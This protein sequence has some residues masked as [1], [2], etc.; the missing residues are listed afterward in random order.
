M[1]I[2]LHIV[3]V[4]VV[5]VHKVVVVAEDKI[6]ENFVG[7]NVVVEEGTLVVVHKIVVVV[8]R[9]EG[10]V[11]E[12]YSKQGIVV[13]SSVGSFVEVDSFVHNF[14]VD[15]FVEGILVVVEDSIERVVVEM[16]VELMS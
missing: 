2:V 7:H 1:D 4:V 16:V 15:S 10:F 8:A 3:V 5:V 13:H 11:E 12:V 9:I 6:V 14:V